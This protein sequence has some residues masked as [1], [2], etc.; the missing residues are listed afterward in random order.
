MSIRLRFTFACI[1][2]LTCCV[3]VSARPDDEQALLA[4]ASQIFG[5][6]FNVEGHAFPLG[7]KYAVWLDIDT[8]GNLWGAMVR[9]KSRDRYA[10]RGQGSSQEEEFVSQADY[11]DALRRISQLKD[12]GSP[13]K[14]GLSAI[15]SAQGPIYA[16]RFDKAVVSRLVPNAR[17]NRIA[18]FSVFYSHDIG[19]TPVKIET[20]EGQP[21][22]CT[23]GYWYYVWP[24]AARKIRIGKFQQMQVA[25]P[26][27]DI[28]SACVPTTTLYDQDGFTIE[29]VGNY[30]ITAQEPYKARTLVGR[31]M[32]EGQP[33][34]DAII[35]VQRV[36][37]KKVLRARS[38]SA[39]NFSITGGSRGQ[40]KF[41]VDKEGFNTLTG[42][43]LIERDAPAESLSFV[44][45]LGT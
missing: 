17:E 19:N 11:E 33:V 6:Q 32:F 30:L 9:A 10:F 45:S 27:E 31:V 43:I 39:G 7:D 25:G 22:L 28:R 26:N 21:L 24:E 12:I 36:N 15:S 13:Q 5:Q 37:S 18:E 4:R 29:N 14:G 40:Y 2:L 44:L 16:Q 41:K 3:A 42:T 34:D 1:A 8:R 20:I 35:Q 23:G 38:D